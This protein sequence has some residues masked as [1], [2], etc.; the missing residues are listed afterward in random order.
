[1]LRLAL[2]LAV[3]AGI[4]VPLAACANDTPQIVTVVVT[5]T[6]APATPP[7]A[8]ALDHTACFRHRTEPG[9]DCAG[10]GDDAHS[11]HHPNTHAYHNSHGHT[12]PCPDPRRN[13]DFN[14][15]TLT[16]ADPYANSGANLHTH[17]PY[18]WTSLPIS[19]RPEPSLQRVRQC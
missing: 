11:Y 9:S 13:S 10:A 16:V 15:N 7:G 6:P 8:N 12:L 2:M 18:G 17:K 5:A 3:V 4:A 14:R 1:M 19:D